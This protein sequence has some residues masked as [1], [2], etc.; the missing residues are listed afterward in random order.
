M[1]LLRLL[2]REVFAVKGGVESVVRQVAAAAGNAL[3]SGKDLN[4]VA[5]GS[6]MKDVVNRPFSGDNPANNTRASNKPPVPV[7]VFGVIGGLILV[8]GSGMVWFVV[9]QPRRKARMRAPTRCATTARST[10]S[11]RSAIRARPSS[12][13]TWPTAP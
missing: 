2:G 13:A 7:W 5:D 10:T 11:R 1:V 8:I 6:E 3:D 12:F 9:L 4:E